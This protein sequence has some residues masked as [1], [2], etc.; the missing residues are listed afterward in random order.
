MTKSPTIERENEIRARESVQEM[1]SQGTFQTLTEEAFWNKASD[2]LAKKLGYE[3]P[4]QAQEASPQDAEIWKNLTAKAMDMWQRGEIKGEQDLKK[5]LETTTPTANQITVDNELEFIQ[6]AADKDI[7][8]VEAAGRVVK[9]LEKLG[10]KV[11]LHNNTDEYNQGISNA[12]GI[13]K[14][15]IDA[16]TTKSNGEFITDK[17]EIHINLENADAK[18]VFHEAFHAVVLGRGF[19]VA[20]ISRFVKAVKK[21]GN[22]SKEDIQKLDDFSNQYEAGE[23]NEE[24]LSELV[25]GLASSAKTM[26]RNQLQKLIDAIN[27]L[28]EK[29]G[30]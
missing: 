4:M 5:I 21:S 25:G 22:L 24:F 15:D 30:L 11:F 12:T 18:T 3:S 17:N 26:S 23:V 2:F 28:F 29:I 6:Q 9:A 14:K 10:V 16:E 19:D 20:D 8:T 27:T 1:S 13:S 7:E